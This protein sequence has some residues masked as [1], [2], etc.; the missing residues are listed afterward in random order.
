M[1]PEKKISI[2]QRLRIHIELAKRLIRL[3][4]ELDIIDEKKYFSLQE[5]L[6]EASKEAY[7]WLLYL[8][9]RQEPPQGGSHP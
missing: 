1:E 4:Q 6:I 9:K 7:G 3:C 5:K 2:I 8:Q